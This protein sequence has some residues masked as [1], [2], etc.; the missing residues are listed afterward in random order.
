MALVIVKSQINSVVK[1]I[2]KRR[3]FRINNVTSD[4][5]EALDKKVRKLVE[6]AME[7]ANENGRKTL[8]GRD[9]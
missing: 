1:E 7:R 8:M 5:P 9:V 3:N 6:E 4:F 2:S